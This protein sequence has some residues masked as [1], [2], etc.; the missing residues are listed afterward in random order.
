MQ[1]GRRPLAA[2]GATPRLHLTALPHPGRAHPSS[3][4]CS[5]SSRFRNQDLCH[6]HMH[7]QNTGWEGGLTPKS[8]RERPGSSTFVDQLAWHHHMHHQDRGWEGGLTP[9]CLR[10]RPGSSTFVDQLA[11]HHHMH[12]QDRG[13][14]GG[15]TPLVF[16]QNHSTPDPSP[17]PKPRCQTSPL[18]LILP[19]R[20]LSPSLLGTLDHLL[21]A[22]ISPAMVPSRASHRR[23]ATVLLGNSRKAVGSIPAGR[24]RP[25]P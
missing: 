20:S 16:R 3:Q 10:E 17:S 5:A 24:N 22:C 13:W 1:S 6:H 8:L 7:H 23:F 11:W 14:E 15:L 25:W 9:K 19:L 21:S 4:S 12:H 18:L 2:P